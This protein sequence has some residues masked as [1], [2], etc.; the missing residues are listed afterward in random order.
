MAYSVNK[1]ILLG[2]LGTDPEV[3]YTQGGQ[4]VANFRMAT[5]E[6][7]PGRDGNRED[8]TEWHNV[9]V[10][11]KLAELCRDYLSKGRKVYVE[12]RLQTR[13]WQDREGK[14][15]YTTEVVAREVVFLDSKGDRASDP[16]E[17]PPRR[18]QRQ[19]QP[20]ADQN[21]GPG[22]APADDLPPPPGIDD[23]IPF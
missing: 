6:S 10:W 4:A 11:A 12:G 22:P 21:S 14:D 7:I 1:V 20:P 8:R 3:R 19:S 13:K 2:N 15:R 9:V 17:G 23:D 18:S 16:G 5:T